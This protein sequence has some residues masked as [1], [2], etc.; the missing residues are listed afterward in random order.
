MKLTEKRKPS[1]ADIF[2]NQRFDNL[3]RA[4]VPLKTIA[5]I[6]VKVRRA[7]KYLFDDAASIRVAEVVRDIPELL[8]R[9]SKFARAPYELTWIEFNSSLFWQTLH[10]DV[11]H[12]DH[13]RNIGILIDGDMVITITGGYPSD[14][15]TTMLTPFAYGL[16]TDPDQWRMLGAPESN[17]KTSLTV[18]QIPIDQFMQTVNRF[19]WGSTAASIPDEIL[20]PISKN[21]SSW[22]IIERVLHLSEKKLLFVMKECQG[23]LRNII[24]LLL[25]LNRPSITRYVQDL[26]NRRGFLRNKLI[27]YQAHTSVTVSLDPKP[28][29]KLI[30]TPQGESVERRWHEVEGHYCHDRTSRDYARIAG[31]LHDWQDTDDEWTLLRQGHAHSKVEHWICKACGGKRW[32]RDSHS[33]GNPLIGM[34]KRD[35]YN[36]VP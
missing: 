7:K 17:L 1:L 34:V 5:D 14:P 21:F 36:V 15:L 13:A 27:A 25:M 8:I 23:D 29:L 19:Y 18:K 22:A 2:V 6:Q 24:A 28:I 3:S 12:E 9:E 4:R 26:P 35:Q 11:G 16:N 10:D 30:G 20:N 32:W 33:R 31:C